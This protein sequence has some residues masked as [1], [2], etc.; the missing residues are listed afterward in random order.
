MRKKAIIFLVF[1]LTPFLLVDTSEAVTVNSS[2]VFT[3]HP[4]LF[5]HGSGGTYYAWEYVIS[6]FLNDGWPA[7]LLFSYTLSNPS[8][9]TNKGIIADSR[10]IEKWVDLILNRTGAD[11][12]DLISHSMGAASTRLYIKN[13][14][15]IDKVDDYVSLAGF[16]HGWDATWVSTQ[17][18]YIPNMYIGE[19][20]GSL[21]VY[22]NN[23]DETPGG[24]LN[25]T[26]GPREG[27]LSGITFNSTHIPGNINYTSIY[28]PADS[29]STPVNCSI[30]DGENNI[31]LSGIN[32]LSF[33]YNELVYNLTRN[34][35]SDEIVSYESPVVDN[36]GNG[37]GDPA[38][39]PGYSFF[40]TFSIIIIISYGL[41]QNKFKVKQEPK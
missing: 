11:K 41:Y 13:L 20:N 16:S 24:F 2:A 19:S 10:E 5:V 29:T 25:D 26:I 27:A 40:I 28:S 22:L 3:Q 14:T 4:I 35:I 33:L 7:E 8:D 38:T 31:E 36:G 34:A 23:G 1:I 32:H 39:I 30:L 15:G 21:C 12:I 37:D 9:T 6:H 18:W 17:S